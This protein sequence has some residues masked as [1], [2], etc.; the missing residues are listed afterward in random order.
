MQALGLTANKRQRENTHLH[1][2]SSL[3]HTAQEAS[4]NQVTDSCEKIDDRKHFEVLRSKCVM[5]TE[6]QVD[7]ISRKDRHRHRRRTT[8]SDVYLTVNTNP[9]ASSLL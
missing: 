1:D 7:E 9:L 6:G 2:G 3:G 8:I 4:K 5:A